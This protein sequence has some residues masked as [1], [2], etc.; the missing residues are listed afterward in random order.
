MATRRYW[1]N[2]AGSYDYRA[3]ASWESSKAPSQIASRDASKEQGQV[4]AG[5]APPV[6][7]GHRDARDARSVD[8]ALTGCKLGE[9]HLE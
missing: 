9:H 7:S 6:V 4:L 2:Q 8:S 1:Y 5:S 3:Q